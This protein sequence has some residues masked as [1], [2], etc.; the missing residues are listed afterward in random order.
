[1][2]RTRVISRTLASIGYDRSTSTLELEFTSG[3]IYQY[4]DV[5]EAIYLQ[6]TGATSRGK[7]FN[8]NVRERFRCVHM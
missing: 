6:L 7:Y 8:Q 2:D 3:S 5:P 1:L 4:F